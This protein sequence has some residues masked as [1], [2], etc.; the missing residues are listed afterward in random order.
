MGAS[1]CVAI[2]GASGTLARP[3]IRLLDGDDAIAEIRALDVRPYQG[4]PSSKLRFSE[5]DVRDLEALQ[6]AFRGA[7][8]VVHL[9]FVVADRV[10]RRADIYAVNILRSYM[11]KRWNKVRGEAPRPGTGV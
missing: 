2:T 7:D 3:L 10:P 11:K 4:P 9:A 5:I 1:L 6:A 8:A